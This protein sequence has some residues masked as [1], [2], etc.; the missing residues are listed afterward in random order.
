MSSI[1]KNYLYNVI[2]QILVIVLPL[3]T[4]PYVSRR[5][6][7]TNIGIYSYTYSVAYY[8]TL[9]AMLG[10]SIHGSRSIAAIRDNKQIMS[11]V[12]WCIY[13]LQ[14]TTCLLAILSYCFYTLIFVS[15]NRTIVWIQLIYVVSSIMDISWLYFGIEEFKFTV[16]R[17]IIIKVLTLISIFVFVKSQSD[18]WKYTLILSGGTFLSQFY[19]W[20]RVKKYVTFYSVKIND[21]LTHIKPAFILFI[22]VI[23]YSVYKIIAKI[24]LGNMAGFDEIGYYE[25]ALKIVN[26]PMGLIT[27]LGT[28]MLPRMTSIV[29][30]GDK[31]KEKYYIFLSIKVITIISAAI[32]FGIMAVS[33]VLAPV[34]YG[35]EFVS[36]AP[37]MFGLAISVFFTA[38]ANVIRTQYLIP[39]K[40]DNIYLIST[41]VGALFSLLINLLFIPKMGA[42]GAVIGTIVAEFSVFC[43]Q[44]FGIRNEFEILTFFKVIWPY[45]LIGLLMFTPVYYYGIASEKSI[46]TLVIQVV[47]G[48]GL[49][50]ILLIVYSFIIKDEIYNQ[51]MQ[52]IQRHLRKQI[53]SNSSK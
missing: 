21:I 17:N 4:A 13:R 50:I 52:V 20:F 1:K 14:F 53:L 44:A 2:Y 25:S 5:L 26:I 3:L 36:S 10:I 49:Y 33:N 24:M 46:V 28:V 42:M 31:N 32:A 23:S 11:K 12:F 8:F 19:L 15:I 40:K 35:E 51:M 37:L 30:S 18:L 29:A 9:F 22:P 6:G 27:A 48:G 43:V 45:L 34:F 47:F 38:W 41:V 7:V 16:T 39:H